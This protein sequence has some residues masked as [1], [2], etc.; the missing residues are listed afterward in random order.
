M[1]LLY[2]PIGFGKKENVLKPS[3]NEVKEF[4]KLLDS[5]KLS[6]KVGFDSCS[7][8]G[9]IN[10]SNTIDM[11]FV[12]YCEGGRF[13]CYIDANMNMM[14]CSFCNQDEKYYVDLHNTTIQKAWYSDVFEDFRNKLKQSCPKCKHRGECG[15]GCPVSRDIVLCGRKEKEFA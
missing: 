1:F 10:F 6:C 2:K 5:H 7:C 12:D 15:G 14:P 3:D 9:M 4:F 11:R 8:P 13:S